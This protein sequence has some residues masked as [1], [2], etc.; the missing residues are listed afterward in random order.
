MADK[1][2][3]YF[4]EDGSKV[5]IGF[6]YNIEKRKKELQTGNNNELKLLYYIKECE[7]SFEKYVHSICQ[8]YRENGE[9]FDKKAIE[10]LL[11][12]S[13]PWYK[14]NMIEA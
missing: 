7:P 11:N 9:W 5:K 12:K 6:S 2:F 3:V 13:S 10:F 8:R 1:G 14:E 4:I